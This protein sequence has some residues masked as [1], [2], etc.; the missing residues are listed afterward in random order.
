MKL[1]RGRFLLVSAILI[2]ASIILFVFSLSSGPAR[3]LYHTNRDLFISIVLEQRLPRTVL[4]WV[5]GFLLALAGAAFQ[6]LFRNRLADPYITGTSSGAALGAAIALVSGFPALGPIPGTALLAS[7]GALAVTLAV[8][9]I[10]RVAGNP[11]PVTALLLAGT[12]LSALSSSLLSLLLV[13]HD[14]D[15][16]RVYYWILGGFSSAWYEDLYYVLPLAGIALVCLL[17]MSRSLDL[18]A[19][20]EDAARS[21]GLS[22]RTTRIAV[23]AGT[24]VAVAAAVS[25]AGVIGFVGLVAPHIARLVAGPRHRRLLPFSALLGALLTLA[26]DLVAR[27]V[28]APAELP[29]GIITSLVGA[30]F[31]LWLLVRSVR[32]GR[33]SL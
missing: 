14:R 19:S 4:A 28:M 15:L 16:H 1:S 23:L 27:S 33:A 2:L 22:L 20:G 13:L 21:L 29:L 8:F 31:F 10:A 6:G 30:P 5:V 3:G 7:L 17:P 9:A 18:L 32:A 25:A 12:A 26:A 11:A 24:S